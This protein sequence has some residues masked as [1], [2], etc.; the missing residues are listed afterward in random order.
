MQFSEKIQP[1]KMGF[2]EYIEALEDERRKIQVFHRE[3]P[4]SLELVAQAIEACRQQLSG[5]TTEYNLNGQ[6]ECS[7]QTSTDDPVFEEFIPIKKRASPDCDEEDDEEY[8]D[9]GEEQHSHR[10]KIQKEDSTN[11]N[12]NNSSCS[13]DKKKSDWLRSVQLW[14]PDPQPPKEDVPRK[15]SVVE[16]K[17]SIGGAFQPFH[18]EESTVG[19]VNASSSSLP[20]AKTPSSPP[21]PATSSTGPVSTGGNAGSGGKRE[22]KGQGQRKQRRCWSQELHKRFLHALQQLGGADSAT[23]KQIREL[24]K[25]DGLTND[26]V[27]SHLQK[28]RLHT[29]RPTTMIPNSANSQT[30]PLFLVGNIF[31]QPQEYAAA[32]AAI[33]TSTVSSGEL[34]TVTTAPHAAIYAPVA[35]HP[36]TIVPRTQTHPSMKKSPKCNKLEDVSDHSHSEERAN[37]G[38]G[39]SPASSSS[40]HGTTSPGC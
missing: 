19:K 31:V 27:K 28:F 34:T 24:M 26:E 17:R 20:T 35:T 12:N 32:T 40:T 29:R 21:V 38:E 4:L 22:E 15:A 36:T 11:N 39:N 25:V 8:Y 2:R 16:V 3:L 7:E 33:A 9:D 30:A 6:S 14:N 10:N 37:H 13:T 18:R 5:T 1:Q 23:P